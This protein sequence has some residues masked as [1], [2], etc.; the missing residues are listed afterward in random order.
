[1]IKK[2]LKSEY[3]SYKKLLYHVN[4]SLQLLSTQ[5]VQDQKLDNSKKKSF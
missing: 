1:M 3:S 5:Q 2:R 4:S